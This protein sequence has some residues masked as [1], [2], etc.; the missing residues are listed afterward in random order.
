[1]TITGTLSWNKILPLSGF[2]LI[3][4]RQTSPDGKELTTVPRTA[5]KPTVIFTD[6]PLE[7]GKFCEEDLAWIHRASTLHP[8]E[9]SKRRKGPTLA[10]PILAI[11][12][13]PILA[14]PILPIQFG[15]IH[16]GPIDFWI[17]RV[18]VVPQTVV[19]NPRKNRAPKGGAPKGGRPKISRFVFPPLP[20]QFSLIL[21]LSGCL[22]VEFWWCLKRSFPSIH[23]WSSRAVV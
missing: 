11:L 1:M 15:P 10:N 8:S 2:S 5:Q 18:M 21:S 12:I 20:P 13:R 16:F 6:N 19:P 22:L 14:N 4:V 9:T 7:F 3:R 17:W 23:V